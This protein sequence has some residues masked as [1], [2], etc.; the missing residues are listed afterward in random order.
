MISK[1]QSRLSK[2]PANKGEERQP[3]CAVAAS[4]NFILDAS[5][6]KTDS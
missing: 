5:D 4:R 2:A 1:P 6:P 3:K